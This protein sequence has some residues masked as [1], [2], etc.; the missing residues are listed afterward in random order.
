MKLKAL[1]L[2]AVGLLAGPMAAS[3][4]NI[5]DWSYTDGGSNTGSGTGACQWT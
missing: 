5:Y 2:I 3:A 1:G 4:N